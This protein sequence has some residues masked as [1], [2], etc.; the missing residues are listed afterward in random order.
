M[1]GRHYVYV[2]NQEYDECRNLAQY[3]VRNLTPAAAS[4]GSPFR[5]D[6]NGLEIRMDSIFKHVA[7]TGM[8]VI[9]ENF[10]WDDYRAIPGEARVQLRV[11]RPFTDA[12]GV[13]PPYK[14]STSDLAAQLNVEEVAEQAVTDQINIVP[15]PFY[16]RSGTGAGSYELAQLDNRVKITNLPQKCTIR[17]F[18]LN[19]Q[20]VRI[21]RKD[22][23]EPDQEWDLRNNFGVPIASGMYLL[24][25]D[26][27]GLGEKILKFFCIL[28]EIDLNAY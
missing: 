24:H 26:A 12:N 21:F 22:S 11:N 18:T 4:G 19:G 1:S 27:E 20:L 15:N 13:R 6:D 16:G 14:F 5:Y 9:P 28:P 25:I 10:V 23:D 8:P 2:T 17:I 3:R 7:W